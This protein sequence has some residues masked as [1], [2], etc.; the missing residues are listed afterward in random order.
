METPAFYY[1]NNNIV[2]F[3]TANALIE[4]FDICY[5]KGVIH[6]FQIDD[7]NE[8][9]YF[10]ENNRKPEHFAT[11]CNTD[12]FGRMVTGNDYT[13]RQ[14]RHELSFWAQKAQKRLLIEWYLDKSISTHNY[15][16]VAYSLCMDFYLQGIYH[17]VRNPLSRGGLETFTRNRNV[18]LEEFDTVNKRKKVRKKDDWMRDIQ[19]L[20]YERARMEKE[21]PEGEKCIKTTA[22]ENFARIF[23]RC[24]QGRREV[25]KENLKLHREEKERAKLLKREKEL[26]N[27]ETKDKT[28]QDT[29]RDAV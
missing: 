28:I 25:L 10:I 18:V 13:L 27:G 8:A 20:C 1:D 22:Y 23:W 12:I 29:S 24:L 7:E 3:Q 17:F 2:N 14:W 4:L 19:M 5:K 6:A 26:R 11:L 15:S 9:R 16:G 21:R